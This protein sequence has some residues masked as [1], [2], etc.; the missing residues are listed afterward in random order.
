MYIFHTCTD[1]YNQY[2]KLSG[3]AIG[4]GACAT[5]R[6]GEIYSIADDTPLLHFLSG[7]AHLGVLSNFQVVTR[8]SV[9]LR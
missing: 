4:V 7:K 8:E 1:G 5:M 3:G 6:Q 2:V 9:P